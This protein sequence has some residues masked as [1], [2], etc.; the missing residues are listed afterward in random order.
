MSKFDKMKQGSIKP[1]SLDFDPFAPPA[2]KP[3]AI[4]PEPA[5]VRPEPVPHP[6][7]I[8]P[9]KPDPVQEEQATTRPIFI[10][11]VDKAE[12]PTSRSFSMY[13]SRHKQVG[14]LAYIEERHPWQIIDDALEL[15][16]KK[17]H[18]KKK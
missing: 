15:Y 11:E 9:T 17:N 18:P 12:K 16:V 1:T 10:T 3:A 4:N 14:D 2:P 13:P 8:A 7:A 5:E 6:E